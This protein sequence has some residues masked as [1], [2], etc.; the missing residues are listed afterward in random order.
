M[1]QLLTKQI[2][3]SAFM[4]PSGISELIF[5]RVFGFA[6]S[7]LYLCGTPLILGSFV[8]QEAACF[9]IFPRCFDFGMS[10]LLLYLSSLL[11]FEVTDTDSNVIDVFH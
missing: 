3:G 1:I 10:L 6:N 9:H 8:L 5:V 7:F 11:R 2:F 4:H